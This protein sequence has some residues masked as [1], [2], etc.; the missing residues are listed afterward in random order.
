MGVRAQSKRDAE[1]QR[2]LKHMLRRKHLRAGLSK[3]RSVEFHRYAAAGYCGQC[4][5]FQRP[6]LSFALRCLRTVAKPFDN[7]HMSYNII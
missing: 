5:Q 4:F 2:L 1:L 7:I 6:H 3:S